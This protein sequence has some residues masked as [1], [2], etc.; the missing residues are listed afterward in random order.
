KKRDQLEKCEK[1]RKKLSNLISSPTDPLDQL[2]KICERQNEG[3]ITARNSCLQISQNKTTLL[4]L[5]PPSSKFSGL[6]YS[7]KS[8][9]ES[10]IKYFEKLASKVI[11][12][13]EEK[14][15]PM[16]LSIMQPK[17]ERRKM[18][19]LPNAPDASSFF[20]N[21]DFSAA[22]LEK[23]LSDAKKLP[24]NL[25]SVNL[26][27]TIDR[28][29]IESAAEFKDKKT[30]KSMNKSSS[31]LSL[32]KSETVQHPISTFGS[33]LSA[34]SAI[35][36]P[37]NVPQSDKPI[38]SSK[39]D[40][41][42]ST[43]FNNVSSPISTSNSSV[44]ES[45]RGSPNF[46]NQEDSGKQR[47]RRIARLR[48]N[49]E[50][51]CVA[52]IANMLD[53]P[54]VGIKDLHYDTQQ[55]IDNKSHVL[56]QIGPLFAKVECT[57]HPSPILQKDPRINGSF[58]T[59]S[60]IEHA[61][62]PNVNNWFED[63][64]RI[65]LQSGQ[66]GQTEKVP[67]LYEMLNDQFLVDLFRN[68]NGIV[69]FVLVYLFTKKYLFTKLIRFCDSIIQENIDLASYRLEKIANYRKKDLLVI[70]S[71]DRK[72]DFEKLGYEAC[73]ENW[74]SDVKL[75]G[76]NVLL[77]KR[78]GFTSDE[79]QRYDSVHYR[80]YS[81][82]KDDSISKTR[83][84]GIIA[85]IDAGK[86]TT[87]ERML[88]YAGYTRRIG[89]VDDG[90]TVMDYMKQE[91]ER[92]IT[93]TSATITF[94]WRNYRINL[95]DTPGHVD[96]T[97]EVER[98]IRVLDGAVTVLDAVAGVEAQTQTV[99]AQANRYNVPRIA[100]VN[101]MDRVGARFGRTV[102]EMR[103]KLGARPLVCQ[104]P[105]MRKDNRSLFCGIVDLLD[106]H[107]LDWNKDPKGSIITRTPLTDK[108]PMVGL[109][110][111]AKRGRSSLIEAL[112]EM[113][114][115]M[116]DLFLSTE[117]HM[118]ISVEDTKQAL[119]RVTL[120]GKAV[121]VFCGA[122][123][124]N[125]GV[126]PLMD[127]VVDYL[128]SPLDR[129]AP[130]AS[131]SGD[132]S[133]EIV[134]KESEKLCALA[135]KVVHD[136]KRGPMV[137]VRVYSGKLDNH[138]TLYNTNT[139]HKE[140]VNKL[141]QVYSNDVEEIPLIKAGNIGVI[142]GLKETRTGD[143]LIQFNDSRKSLRL[144]N[145]DI[146]APVFFRVVEAAGISEE[147]PLEEALKSIL[148]EDPS[149]HVYVDPDS[150]QTLISGMGELHLEIVK[151]RLLND[152]KVKAEL[153]K[154]RIS[155]RETVTEK[156]DHTYLYERE[157]MGKRVRAQIALIITP[158]HEND[159]GSSKEGGNRITLNLT[160]KTI[161]LDEIDQ[162]IN[163]QETSE[164]VKLSIE[165]ISNAVYTGIISGLYRGPML[166]F[167]ITG[168]S[169]NVYSLRLFGAESTKIAISTC[170]SRALANALKDR[171]LVLLEPLMNVNID[172]PEEY[173]GVVLGDLTGI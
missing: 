101:K 139:C 7:S 39:N 128:P 168:L 56:F 97:V 90:T 83:N 169:I 53:L 89:D 17:L 21:K 110:D 172:V 109:Y 136:N 32:P 79:I 160:K 45:L 102:R 71:E 103:Y 104:I 74:A 44:S 157:I 49:F 123:F 94:A 100:Y 111:E 61:Q 150:G 120:N 72:K 5:R 127:A 88:Y 170:A 63:G 3:L 19:S 42:L 50:K 41:R 148:R 37:T 12:I 166:G 69:Q 137:F 1:E 9:V 70:V 18:Y 30:I 62:N 24:Q 125:I 171:N 140:R 91:R 51:K 121:P 132:E 67:S 135:F 84:I 22:F 112:S 27:T 162:S 48:K 47:G 152:F 29:N 23:Q 4:P 142:I 87:T 85:H 126:Q 153:G 131:L 107:I 86:T 133:V 143:T 15:K 149:L 147:K 165:D 81:S 65:I 10:S 82:I 114:D 93:I 31:I 36:K 92:G 11:P 46:T 25:T 151:D 54:K 116:L 28:S 43:I 146:P 156:I 2:Q 60:R 77:C 130:I 75:C 58:L 113:D 124:R 73:S 59:F 66:I 108:H 158:L 164:L 38:A 122:S 145:I 57:Y 16:P 118:K 134:P 33:M 52:N 14:T 115:N 144:Q 154:M 8:S 141:L 105:V 40:V 159:Q 78:V 173:L 55:H 119:R 68:E 161:V 64:Q 76:N 20:V 129:P 26:H 98:S 99:W 163:S 117:D 80:F 6:N 34:T 13:N 96:F 155:Y 106:M 138:M 167:P 95:I 35:N